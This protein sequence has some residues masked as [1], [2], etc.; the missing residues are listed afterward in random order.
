MHGHRFCNLIVAY[1]DVSLMVDNGV[2]MPK[3]WM[4][5]AEEEAI[6]MA[7]VRLLENLVTAHRQFLHHQHPTRNLALKDG[8][9]ED[10]GVHSQSI[11]PVILFP[12][13]LKIR[14]KPIKGTLA[15]SNTSPSDNQLAS[16]YP[17]KMTN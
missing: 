2:S 14:V 12:Q 16:S 3:G 15:L 4:C 5:L 11:Y 1:S 9:P 17:K 6:G 13:E 10:I 8:S 7:S